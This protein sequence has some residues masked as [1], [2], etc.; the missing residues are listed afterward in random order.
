MDEKLIS[1]DT[2]RHRSRRKGNRVGEHELGEIRFQLRLE[3]NDLRRNLGLSGTG[4]RQLE[5]MNV[6]QRD[7]P[8]Q[9]KGVTQETTRLGQSF[10]AAF[11]AVRKEQI[12]RQKGH[13]QGRKR[14]QSQ[15][16]RIE[17]AGESHP[18]QEKQ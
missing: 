2:D 18:V 4:Y 13:D 16:E 8:E 9:P 1:R 14:T 10:T 17:L 15:V 11:L 12:L 5:H 6:R 7:L 3:L